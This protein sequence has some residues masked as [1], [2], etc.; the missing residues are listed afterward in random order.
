LHRQIA[1]RYD[2]GDSTH[3]LTD[4]AEGFPVHVDTSLFHCLNV[5]RE[6]RCQEAPGGCF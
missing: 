3:D 1:D 5:G 6:E 4:R 2:H